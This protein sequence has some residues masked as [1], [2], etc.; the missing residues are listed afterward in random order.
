MSRNNIK[1]NIEYTIEGLILVR[2][3][4]GDV[5][6]KELKSS[7]EYMIDNNLITKNMKGI[8]SDF[9]DTNFLA[10]QK[11]LLLLKD[12]FLKHSKILGHL[13]FVQIINTPKIA[14]TMLFEI[15]NPDV[16]TKSFSTMQAARNWIN[17]G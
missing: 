3:F 15:E 5:T 1:I 10:E 13:R 14:Q 16:T 8:I 9:R 12:L 2:K 17:Q 11:D 6:I 7:L 4:F